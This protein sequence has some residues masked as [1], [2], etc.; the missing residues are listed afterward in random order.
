MAPARFFGDGEF[1]VVQTCHFAAFAACKVRVNVRRAFVVLRFEP[2][3]ATHATGHAEQSSFFEFD[4]V[5]V[6]GG[7]V[8]IALA[9]GG[10]HFGM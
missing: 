3:D 4:E 2:R 5:S 6:K 7:R 8:P 10:H 9:N 1:G